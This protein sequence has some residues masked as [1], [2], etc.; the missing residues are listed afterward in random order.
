M[1]FAG[2]L[3]FATACSGNMAP[4]ASPERIPAASWSGRSNAAIWFHPMPAVTSGSLAGY[5]STDF[6]SL[7]V[8]GAPWPKAL[9]RTHVIGLYAGWVADVDAGTL[10]PIVAFLNAHGIAIE[11]EA[12]SLQALPTCGTGLEGYVPYGQSLQ[13]FTL[14]YL[15]RLQALHANVL[16]MKI[17]EPFFFG[18]VVS[19][20]NSCHF[21]VADLASQVA[22]FTTLVHSVN[23]AIAVGDVEPVIT[24]AGYTPDAVTALQNWHDAYA[25]ANGSQFPFFIADNDFSNPGWPAL[26]RAL[27]SGARQRQ[28]K[29]GI[30]YI[31]DPTDTTDAEWISKV[32]SRYETYEFRSG[33]RPDYALFQSWETHPKY[34]LPETSA[35]TFTGALDAYLN[36]RRNSGPRPGG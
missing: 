24:T 26:D 20:S 16:Y 21:S 7:F 6:A 2:M 19:D 18:S 36:A 8:A 10:D 23:P 32:E 4:G 5:G 29:F 13:A 31:G 12:P 30:I 15:Q 14:S 22:E 1:P 33:G 35:N 27:E 25:K 17:D 3:A 9:A 28:M 34:C 11:L